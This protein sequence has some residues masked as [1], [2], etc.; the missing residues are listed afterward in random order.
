M[1]T[2][3]YIRKVGGDWTL[4]DSVETPFGQIE[5]YTMPGKNCVIEIGVMNDI[6][7]IRAKDARKTH[8]TSI[9]AEYQAGTD[10]DAVSAFL[11]NLVT[12]GV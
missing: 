4:R 7:Y 6:V 10:D 2:V 5:T 9:N 11:R 8:K 3:S 12:N 1:N